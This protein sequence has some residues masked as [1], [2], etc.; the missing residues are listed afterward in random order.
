MREYI[1]YE[2]AQIPN[3]FLNEKLKLTCKNVTVLYQFMPMMAK[4]P[5]F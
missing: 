2:F 3:N 5:T 1:K 4:M